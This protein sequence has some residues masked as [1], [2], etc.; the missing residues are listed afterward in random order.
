M[1]MT[2]AAFIGMGAVVGYGLGAL[3]LAA[4]GSKKRHDRSA[5]ASTGRHA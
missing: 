1:S 4:L 3:L 5:R 2:A